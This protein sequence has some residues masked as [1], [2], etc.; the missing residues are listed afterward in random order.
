LVTAAPAASIDRGVRRH[1][2]TLVVCD[3]IPVEAAHHA[4]LKIDEYRE[5]I[6]PDVPGAERSGEEG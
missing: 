3:R 2:N 1:I 5:M 6:S 4:F